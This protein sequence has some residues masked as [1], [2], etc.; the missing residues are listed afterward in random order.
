MKKKPTIIINQVFGANTFE[1]TCFCKLK[2]AYNTIFNNSNSAVCAGQPNMRCLIYSIK[3]TGAVVYK[4]KKSVKIPECSL[5]LGAMKDMALIKSTSPKWHFLCYW[6]FMENMD[7]E[8][9][10]LYTKKN[11]DYAKE[12]EDINTF[13]DLMQQGSYL[14][15]SLASS[16]F[17]TKM[18]TLLEQLDIYQESANPLLIN[19]IILYINSHIKEKIS[20][21]TIAQEFG[22][23]EKHIRYLFNQHLNTTPSKYIDGLKL[24]QIL[25]MLQTTSFS[26]EYFAETFNYSSAS[27]LISNF[28]KRFKYT[29]KQYL[30]RIHEL[31]EKSNIKEKHITYET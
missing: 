14:K 4:N 31:Q 21:K 11:I 5:F 20:T 13:I 1:D 25:L 22:Y 10:G 16:L 9:N 26:L 8:F 7:I 23:C 24:D 29:P 17:T 6:Y 15:L 30:L 27:H 12:V 2:N 3:G 19:K 28:K 18:I